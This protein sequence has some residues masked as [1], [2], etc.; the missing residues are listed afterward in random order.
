M[1]NSWQIFCIYRLYCYDVTAVC[2][3]LLRGLRFL[4]TLH[5]NY[6]P[7]FLLSAIT[8]IFNLSSF[9]DADGSSQNRMYFF[10]RN[11]AV[12]IDFVSCLMV[13]FTQ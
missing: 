4:V 8:N 6:F 7:S 1:T 9:A 2:H 10:S 12:I 13:F 5:T 3:I 11:I